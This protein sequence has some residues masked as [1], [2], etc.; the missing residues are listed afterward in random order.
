MVYGC[1]T[2]PKGNEPQFKPSVE[3]VRVK[4]LADVPPKL[5]PFAPVNNHQ[6]ASV[7]SSKESVGLLRR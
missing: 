6:V 5:G 3:S 1:G 2:S 7:H 4:S